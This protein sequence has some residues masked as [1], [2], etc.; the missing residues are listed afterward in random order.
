MTRIRFKGS[1]RSLLLRTASLLQ[2]NRACGLSAPHRSSPRN[3]ANVGRWRGVSTDSPSSCP[4]KSAKRV[5]ALDDPGIHVFFVPPPRRGWPGHRR[6]E[7]TPSF[8]RLCPAMT[9]LFSGNLLR[10]G[11][12]GISRKP[13]DLGGMFVPAERE[14]LAF[15]GEVVAAGVI[16]HRA[17]VVA[18][19]GA[20]GTGQ[21]FYRI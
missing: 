11:V 21:V 17:I 2:S 8:G 20:I 4:G 9:G 6:S 7:A 12:D 1:P 3:S 13:F 5:F 19:G 18:V 15:F 16:G 10:S 14:P